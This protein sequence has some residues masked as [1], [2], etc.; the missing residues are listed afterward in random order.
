MKKKII[1]LTLCVAMVAIAIVGGTL[2]YFTDTDEK[3]NV[4]TVGDIDIEINE[5]N[6]EGDEN[7]EYDEWLKEQTIMPGEEVDKIVTVENTGSEDAYVRVTIT[8]PADMTPVF[9]W[10]PDETP[11]AY[12]WAVDD[13]K[14]DPDNGVYVYY[15]TEKLAPKAET[16]A[17]LVA[18]KLNGDVT[19]ANVKDPY[20]VDVFAEGIQ[21]ASFGKADEAIAALDEQL[22]EIGKTGTTVADATALNAAL[23]AGDKVVVLEKDITNNDNTVLKD[24]ATLDG[25]GKTL[26]K[27]NLDVVPNGYKNAGVRPD[28]GTIKNITIVGEEAKTAGNS[29]LGFRAIFAPALT[30]DLTIENSSLTGV[31]AFN[32]DSLGTNKL[33]VKDS[34]I[35]GWFSYGG[36]GGTAE[37]TNVDF[38]TSDDKTATDKD[39][40]PLYLNLVRTYGNATTFTD[41]AFAENYRFDTGDANNTITFVNCTV[42]TAPITAANVASFFDVANCGIVTVVVDGTTVTING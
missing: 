29:V 11:A 31:Y 37:F 17:L 13:N 39:G 1:A 35:N 16:N 3:T 34:T 15:Y 2:A 27:D 14:N 4:F 9:V 26:T 19:E 12:K 23:E 20:E 40:K 38:V 6:E 24:G 18:M 5:K 10:E 32:A 28:S 7:A 36:T 21:A 42:G 22:A 25:N 8:V 30:G 33:T 41:C